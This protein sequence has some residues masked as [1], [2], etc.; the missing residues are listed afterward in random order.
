MKVKNKILTKVSIW[1]YWDIDLGSG[2]IRFSN[3]DLT[4][5]DFVINGWTAVIVD[6]G[7][8]CL[9]NVNLWPGNTSSGPLSVIMGHVY[10]VEFKRT[11]ITGGIST[12][13]AYAKFMPTSY[14][15]GVL[16]LNYV[17]NL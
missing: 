14:Q 13:Y 17:P 3:L 11:V 7:S 12:T 15:G 4:V 16:R 1:I 5:N 6:V 2:Y 8:Y 9:D 10:V